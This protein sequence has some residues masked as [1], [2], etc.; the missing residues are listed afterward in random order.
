[1]DE[2]LRARAEELVLL[3]LKQLEG[4]RDAV[5]EADGEAPITEAK[6]APWRYLLSLLQR[7]EPEYRCNDCGEPWDDSHVLHGEREPVQ[8]DEAQVVAQTMA[9]DP[10]YQQDQ[11]DANPIWRVAF[12]LSEILNDNAPIGWGGYIYAAE[13]LNKAL[14]YAD[15]PAPELVAW[16]NQQGTYTELW[17][18]KE[19]A[20]QQIEDWRATDTQTAPILQTPLYA[21][22]AAA[23]RDL[24]GKSL[25]KTSYEELVRDH[26]AMEKLRKMTPYWAFDS[27]RGKLQTSYV[28]QGADPAD[29]I[30]LGEQGDE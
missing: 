10:T 16:M 28:G 25:P 6:I 1:M 14:T 22:P 30:L 13:R 4:V 18:N 24:T 7:D 27:N 15:T 2:E 8:R 9:N 29:A 20:D 21:A 11:I 12:I 17:T 5:L 3:E 19:Q 26:L 23:E